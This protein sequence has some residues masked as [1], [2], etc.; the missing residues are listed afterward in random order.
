MHG[1]YARHQLEEAAVRRSKRKQEWP[2]PTPG[3]SKPVEEETPT[4][5]TPETEEQQ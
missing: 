2:Q 5:T 1:S 3:A 4:N